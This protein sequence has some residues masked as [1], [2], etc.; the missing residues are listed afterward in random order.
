MKMNEKEQSLADLHCHILPGV[1][2]GAPNLETALALLGREYADGVRTVILTP[3]YRLNMFEATEEQV[4]S[5]YSALKAAAG[6]RYPELS[7]Y[8][9][10]EVHSH[11]EMA[12]CIGRR[13]Q[14]RMAGSDFV[15]VEFKEESER[16]YIHKRLYGLRSHGFI[17]IIA[18]AE[19]CDALRRDI[20]FVRSLT[21]LG[22]RIQV[23]ADSILGNDGFR[24]KSFC[25]ELVK[26]DLLSFVGSDAHDLRYRPPKIG[27][28][29]RYL[30]KKYGWGYMLRI[31]SEGPLEIINGG[32]TWRIRKQMWSRLTSWS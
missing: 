12:D 31:M 14:L 4:M 6:E 3:H 30:G 10:A 13:P 9:G 26:A 28:C 8:I 15:L 21:E 27:E 16:S 18:H 2:D 25:K 32:D 17:P 22:V 1:D 11:R 7:L 23:N 5:A 24:A 20:G 19:R 29:A